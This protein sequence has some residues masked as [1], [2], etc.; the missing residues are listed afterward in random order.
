MLPDAATNPATQLPVRAVLSTILATLTSTGTA[1]LVAPPG[2][3]KTTLVPLALADSLDGRIIVAEPRR[4]A[5]RA[6]ARRMAA[7]TGTRVG[8][9]I[10]YSVRGQHQTSAA[11]CVEVVTTGILLRRLQRDPDLPGV[12]AVI[13]DE[14][15]ERHLDTDLALA[16][17]LDVRAN[18]RPDLALLATSATA[19]AERLAAVMEAA[20]VIST[21]MTEHPTEIIWA[22]AGAIKPAYGMQVDPKLLDHVAATIRRAVHEADGDVLVF[23]PGAWEI[24]AVASRLGRLPDVDVLQLHGRQAAEVQ[25]AALMPAERRRIVLATAVAESSLTVPGVRIVVDSGLAREPRVDHAR[26]LGSLVTVRVSKA[27]ATQRAGRAA[28]QGPGRVYRCWSAA[29]HERLADH[30]QPELAIADL[31]GFALEL[32]C[33]GDPTGAGLRLL[34]APPAAAMQVARDTLRDLG[35]LD[36]EDRITTRGRAIAAVGAHPRL[37][38]ALIDGG[39]IVGAE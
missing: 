11:T 21:P 32:A 2:A 12:G 19:D 26:G 38:R 9:L 17:L 31:T 30:A 36:S 22:P 28:R 10:G 23:L 35:A 15:H 29:D 24:N 27:T 14:C 4:V 3:G 16:F 37:A 6:A 39:E 25:D 20:T 18:L 5:A 8:D 7:L 13:L 34:D 33:W 1:V